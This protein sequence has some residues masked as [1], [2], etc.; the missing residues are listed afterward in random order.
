MSFNIQIQFEGFRPMWTQ[1]NA[2]DTIRD[3]MNFVG[4]RTGVPVENLMVLHYGRP[5][6]PDEIIGPMIGPDGLNNRFRVT[7]HVRPIGSIQRSVAIGPPTDLGERHGLGLAG[8]VSRGGGGGG[9]GAARQGPTPFP[10]PSSSRVYTQRASRQ[11][12]G[13]S[14][15][16]SMIQ[17]SYARDDPR[18][19]VGG[20]WQ[21]R[22]QAPTDLGERYRPRLAGAVSAEGR[23]R[24]ATVYQMLR[25]YHAR[26][27][28]PQSQRVGGRGQ[29]QGPPVQRMDALVHPLYS[30]AAQGGRVQ[31]QGGRGGRVQQQGGR[32]GRVQQQGGRVQQQGGRG[33]RVQQQGG[34]GGRIQQQAQRDA[35]LTSLFEF[36][37][38]RSYN[39]TP[40]R[41]Q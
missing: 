11:P 33:G 4:I 34:R 41:E 25:A 22:S 1:L 10:V 17:R 39:R 27:R 6:Y 2:T 5:C 36:L 18:F 26:Q 20:I 29:Q 23:A 35:E 9:G 14:Q 28:E 13:Q 15:A 19:G 21:G 16:P 7:A 3:I 24:A 38:G 31:Q 40:R 37:P 32:G 8:A 30:V 12:R